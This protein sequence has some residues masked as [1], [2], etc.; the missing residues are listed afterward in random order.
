MAPKKTQKK[1]TSDKGEL[2][3]WHHSLQVG[4]IAGVLYLVVNLISNS[5]TEHL[6]FLRGLIGAATVFL[7]ATVFVKTYYHEHIKKQLAKK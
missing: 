1:K 3:S 2:K 4:G 7:I 6:N 5:L